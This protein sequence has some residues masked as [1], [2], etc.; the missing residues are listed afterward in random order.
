LGT[1]YIYI[2][3]M[4]L[5]LAKSQIG[6]N[7]IVFLQH[8]GTQTIKRNEGRFLKEKQRKRRQVEVK[9]TH[10]DRKMT[11]KPLNVDEYVVTCMNNQKQME[12]TG[13]RE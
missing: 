1:T 8:S 11:A 3:L 2:K 5:S 13:K 6:N 4:H 12:G 7:F 10:I 9:A